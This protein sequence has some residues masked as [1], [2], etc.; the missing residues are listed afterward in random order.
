M[1]LEIRL[2]W[3]WDYSIKIWNGIKTHQITKQSEK[4]D[5]FKLDSKSLFR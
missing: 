1:E 2:I 3:I 4:P 5:P